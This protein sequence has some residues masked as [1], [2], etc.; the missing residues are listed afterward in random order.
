MIPNSFKIICNTI[1]ISILDDPNVAVSVAPILL[2][3]VEYDNEPINGSK[4]NNRRTTI[5][6]INDCL[7]KDISLDGNT[8]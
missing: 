5:M 3:P 8:A 7:K 6:Y 1:V 2:K 4:E